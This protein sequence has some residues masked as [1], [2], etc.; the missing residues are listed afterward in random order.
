MHTKPY[1]RM[2]KNLEIHRV[3]SFYSKKLQQWP[4]R[5]MHVQFKLDVPQ[6]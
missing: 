4:N 2:N 5:L 3:D 1:S 6:K